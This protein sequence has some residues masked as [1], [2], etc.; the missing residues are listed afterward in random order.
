MDAKTLVQFPEGFPRANTA[1]LLNDGTSVITGHDNG[2]VVRSDLGTGRHDI[3]ADCNF[4]VTAIS[5]NQNG[6]V[7]IGCH[8]GLL[9]IFR[10]A[11]PSRNRRVQEPGFGI[12]D[13]IWRVVWTSKDTF[14][15]SGNYGLLTVFHRDSL[16]NWGS[17]PL[18]GHSPHAIFGLG[19][20]GKF[21][22]SGDYI[23]R[24]MIHAING[25]EFELVDKVAV[26]GGVQGI[27]WY[28]D[29]VF[30]AVDRGGRIHVLESE[31]GKNQWREVCGTDTA[32]S[33][34]TSVHITGDGSTVYAGTGTEFIQLDRTSQ[35]VQQTSGERVNGVFSDQKQVYLVHDQ[36]ITSTP[37]V[38]LRPSAQFTKYRYSKISL[39]GSTGLGKSTLSSN[40]VNRTTEGLDSTF[41]RRIWVK[42]IERDRDGNLNRIILHDHGGQASVLETYL[43]FLT[44]SDIVLIFFKKTSYDTFV[45]ALTVLGEL[46]EIMGRQ[47]KVFLVQ[48]FSESKMDDLAD[49]TKIR[50]LIDSGR[51]VDCIPVDSRNVS[52]VDA[53]FEKVLKEISWPTAKTMIESTY[54]EAALRTL[55][56]LYAS[57]SK[58]V[59]VDDVRQKIN[60]ASGL[61]ISE[62]HLRFLLQNMSSQGVVEYY[63]EF[64]DKVIL[65]DERYN[66]LRTKIPI[67]VRNSNGRVKAESILGFKP[68]EYSHVIDQ[69]F[70][71]YK[72]SL[73]DDGMRIFPAKLKIGKV[74]PPAELKP[75]LASATYTER[76][77]NKQ[78]VKHELII[79]S[80]LDLK[81]HCHDASQSAGIFSFETNAIVYYTF[82]YV[83]DAIMGDKLRFSFYVGGSKPETCARLAE[84]F[85]SMLDQYFGPP[86]GDESKKKAA[87]KF[88]YAVALS[89]AGEQRK[90]AQKVADIIR[91]RLGPV[92]FFDEYMKPEMWGEDLPSFFQEAFYKE[93]KWCMMFV[94]KEYVTKKWPSF[95]AK[96]IIARQIDQ[97]GR[98]IL[99]VHFD[100][101]DVPGLPNTLQHLSVP[102]ETAESIA[103]CFL[104]KYE[105]EP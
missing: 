81:L 36:K 101:T 63:P 88:K 37:R 48:T 18:G 34:G 53:L 62:T 68:P 23:G 95:E 85:T 60:E 46:T 35:I 41:G 49:P 33:W 74:E 17:R 25:P 1:V 97:F 87:K 100:D 75:L 71:A 86:L 61:N 15:A 9:Y 54:S 5:V 21:L 50:S 12:R 80:L 72:I 22:A 104:E 26:S 39:V 42:D 79:E 32:T 45:E 78:Q 93:S 4:Q 59:T 47:T 105:K 99:P 89:F 52:D 20:N 103:K 31:H 70:L 10:L 44:D 66:E 94:S 29:E 55:A 65:N 40:F 8:S 64:F 58:V 6:E 56:A 27:V 96:H 76:D 73:E 13:R 3:L 83:E 77:Y 84:E 98:Y 14:V 57:K 43:P 11:D 51:I 102:P 7:I 38:E 67:F 2:L 24:I 92:V 82:S 90:T 28:S 19:T 91:S 16:G 30:A 69:V